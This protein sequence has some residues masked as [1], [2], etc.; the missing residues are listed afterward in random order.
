MATPFNLEAF[1]LFMRTLNTHLSAGG[2]RSNSTPGK[3]SQAMTSY[4]LFS[5]FEPLGAVLGEI[6]GLFNR[7]TP[8]DIKSRPNLLSG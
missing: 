6:Q 1:N 2:Q 5:H 3:D 8:F 4:K 7:I